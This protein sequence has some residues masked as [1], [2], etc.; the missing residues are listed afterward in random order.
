AAAALFYAWS[1]WQL[2][3]RALATASGR[4]RGPWPSAF[5][6]GE[7]RRAAVYR[8]ALATLARSRR[9]SLL[10]AA[11]LG[12]A[13]AVVLASLASLTW[14]FPSPTLA[15]TDAVAL[16]APLVL[17]C[18]IAVGLRHAFAI[19]IEIRANWLFRVAETEAA[20]V[21]AASELPFT[22][23]SRSRGGVPP[24][25][26]PRWRQAIFG[27]LHLDRLRRRGEA[28]QRE[29]RGEAPQ[30]V[31]VAQR[32]LAARDILLALAVLPP[33]LLGAVLAWRIW[34]WNIAL[35]QVLFCGS[36]MLLWIEALLLRFP[37][38]PF[39]CPYVS[40]RANLKLW[41][42]AYWLTFSTFA[43]GSAALE[44]RWWPHPDRI[45][46]AS[47]AALAAAIALRLWNRNWLAAL[48]GCQL[49]DAPEPVVQQLFFG[50]GTDLSRS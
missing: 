27:R 2:P 38:I 50:A 39:T 16:A 17:C 4:T 12:F 35:L 40:G 24:A 28:D 46:A 18:L 49:E 29:A 37:K 3:R 48:P 13:L 42:F 15:Q 8:F 19:P 5:A 33:L 23:T 11:W 20:P 41:G 9:H 45:V 1:C 10:L 44:R 14:T 7:P 25:V 36:L 30:N 43:F 21:A 26:P 32:L 34:G 47:A 22:A 31:A 6:A